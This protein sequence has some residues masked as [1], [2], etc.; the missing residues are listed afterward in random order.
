VVLVE[1]TVGHRVDTPAATNAPARSGI[2]PTTWNTSDWI[3][4]DHGQ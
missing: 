3:Q 2:H 1:A 4:Y